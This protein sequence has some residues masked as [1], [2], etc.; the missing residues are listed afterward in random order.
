[1]IEDRPGKVPVRTNHGQTY[2]LDVLTHSVKQWGNNMRQL[3]TFDAFMNHSCA[4]NS[5]SRLLSK[6]AETQQ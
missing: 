2:I 4:P 5:E 3:Y 6:T 1:M